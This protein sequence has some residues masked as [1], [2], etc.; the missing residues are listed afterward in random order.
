MLTKEERTLAIT[1]VCNNYPLGRIQ[2]PTRS[3]LLPAWTLLEAIPFLPTTV[4]G[5]VPP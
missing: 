1:P 4:A 2:R 3:V 5:L